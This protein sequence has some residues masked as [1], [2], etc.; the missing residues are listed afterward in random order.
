[1]KS[2]PLWAPF[3]DALKLI[4]T[5]STAQPL[6]PAQRTI[7]LNMLARATKDDNG[8]SLESP[9]LPS[10]ETQQYCVDEQNQQ[11][12][13][14]WYIPSLVRYMIGAFEE[15]SIL[16]P[17]L[18][19]DYLNGLVDTNNRNYFIYGAA[20]GSNM[21]ADSE[22]GQAYWSLICKELDLK[23]ELAELLRTHHGNDPLRLE[24]QRRMK[25]ELEDKLRKVKRKI[26][27]FGTTHETKIKSTPSNQSDWKI[28]A[29][30]LA[31]GHLQV[32][33]HLSIEQIAK[34]VHSDLAEK[35]IAGRGGRVPSPETIKRHALA[36]IKK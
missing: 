6:S 27:A 19:L 4:L 14:Y 35:K 1:M 2:E 30:E 17:P 16:N 23:N 28:I 26:S 36:G 12:E 15:W 18:A 24:A 22:E 13:Q 29:R 33:P 31:T 11:Y 9:A 32:F 20:P 8:K 3:S 7:F 10:V 5:G 21:W 34:K 25:K